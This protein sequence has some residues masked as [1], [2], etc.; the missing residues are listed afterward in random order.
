MSVTSRNFIGCQLCMVEPI[1][2]LKF[3]PIVVV[4]SLPIFPPTYIIQAHHLRNQLQPQNKQTSWRKWKDMLTRA[5]QIPEK[6]RNT[7]RH[8]LIPEL[9]PEVNT[10]ANTNATFMSYT[11]IAKNTSPTENTTHAKKVQT[12]WNIRIYTQHHMLTYVSNDK[13]PIHWNTRVSDVKNT[14]ETRV[15]NSQNN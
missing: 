3:I 12:V 1:C 6:M 15:Y 10:I 13:K 9:P 14:Y 8:N 4:F 2:P 5:Y 11:N 7:T